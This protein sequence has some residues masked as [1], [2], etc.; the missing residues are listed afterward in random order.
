MMRPLLR[1]LWMLAGWL[2]LLILTTLLYPLAFLP[3]RV[4]GRSWYRKL[5]KPWC[6]AWTDA[7]GINLR[8]HRHN[9]HN[10]LDVALCREIFPIPSVTYIR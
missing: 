5:F 4:H 8:L 6:K 10:I 7:P 2:E 9:R 1:W 3:R